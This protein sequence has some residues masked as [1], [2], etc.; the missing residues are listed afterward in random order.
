MA[1]KSLFGRLKK[2]FASNVV[3]R[4]VGG[5]KLKVS[6]TS[7]LQSSGNLKTQGGIDRWS[8]L[9]RQ[10]HG[11]GYGAQ[12]QQNFQYAKS[13]LYN[14]YEAMD[15]DSIISSALDIYADES[16]MK[17]E[18]G[19]VLLIRSDKEDIQKVVHNLMYDVLNI[20]FNLW[21]WVR[22]LCKYGDFFL[23]LDIAEK[24]GIVNVVPLSPYEIWREEGYDEENPYASRFTQDGVA[25]KAIYESFEMAHFRLLSDTNFLPYGRAMVEPARKTWKQLTMMEDAMMIH[26]IMRAPEKR[27][28]NIDVGNIPPDEVDGYMQA[29]IDKMKKVPFVDSQ[30]GDYNLKFNIQ[31]MMEDFYLPTRGGESGT[32]IE[33]LSGLEFNA[34]DDIEYLKNKMMSALRVPKAFLGYEEG[35]EGKAT[36][37]AEDI[38]FARTIERIQRI[39]VSE[40]TKIAIVHLYTQGYTDEDLINFE[41]S[42]TTPST[43]YEQEK[44]SLWQE[45]IRLISDMQQSKV[46][47][48]KWMYENILNMSKEQWQ[49]EQN[50]VIKDLQQSFRHSQIEQEGNDP[51]VTG[52]KEMI[53]GAASG[54]TAGWG[55]SE[56]DPRRYESDL[57][58]ATSYERERYGKREFKG[59][60][61]LYPGKGSTIVA[62]EGLLKSLKNTFG[63]NLK[64]KSILSEEAI[65]DED[66]E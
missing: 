8:R 38:R 56:P 2:L 10:S 55:G 48:N 51:S 39:V 62:K 3:I 16:T 49:R 65:L 12:V 4:N 60:S 37:A 26:R 17:N 24:Y 34:I 9:R 14:D 58:D 43:V 19:D 18:F 44:V 20:E 21:P 11:G 28:F 63:K 57:D 7:R 64:D 54:I 15:T 59:G 1:D 27:M 61:P 13:E 32:R 30:T 47:S 35:I 5:R 45:K 29:I 42:L 22:N 66:S 31:N 36:L 53:G 25:G 23:K 6:D 46:I 41:L 40:L 52:E 33:S 50:G